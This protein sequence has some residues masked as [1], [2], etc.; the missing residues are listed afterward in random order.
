MSNEEG[1]LPSSASG[2]EISRLENPSPL[3]QPGPAR[4]ENDGIAKNEEVSADDMNDFDVRM[5]FGEDVHQ[6]IREYIQLAD[7]K[8]AFFFTAAAAII[9]YLSS[10]GDLVSWLI[11]LHTWG[12]YE[13]LSFLATIFLFVSIA[14]CLL[15]VAPRLGGNANGIIYFKAVSEY[16]NGESYASKV[17]GHSIK[18]LHEEKLKHAYELSKV[19]QRKYSTLFFAIWAGTFGYLFTGVLLLVK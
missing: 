1:Q 4:S 6:Y 13:C 10:K 5:S 2:S 14:C 12:W 17:S 19:C 3:V 15:V 18:R 7:Q 16:P 8:A 9:A 11:P